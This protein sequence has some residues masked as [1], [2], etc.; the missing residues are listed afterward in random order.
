[1]QRKTELQTEDLTNKKHL[2]K[3][4]ITGT[5]VQT[6]KEGQSLK[7]DAIIS[8]HSCFIFRKRT[9]SEI[10]SAVVE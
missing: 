8:A 9:H 10:R 2:E 5:H 4:T 1:M 3:K 7:G 6:E